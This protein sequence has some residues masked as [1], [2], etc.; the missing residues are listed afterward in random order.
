MLRYSWYF[1]GNSFIHRANPAVKITALLATY[2]FIL[3]FQNP[4]LIGILLISTIMLL[5]LSKTPFYLIREMVLPV[6]PVVVMF[7]V[8]WPIS[9]A[10][11]HV[12]ASYT[13]PGVGWVLN[14]TDLGMVWGLIVALRLFTTILATFLVMVTTSESDL[15]SGLLM[16]R[17]PYTLAFILILT[18]RFLSL[19]A[20][21][22]GTIHDA[23]RARALPDKQTMKESIKNMVTLVIPLLL[24]SVRRMQ[25]VTNAIEVRAFK[26]GQPRTN[27]HRLSFRCNDY[28]LM[29]FFVASALCASVLRLH[30]GA[31]AIIPGRP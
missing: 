9:F 1:S 10:E 23:R 12:L 20:G 15:V 27:Y 11:G 24:V 7:T 14:I 4:V 25:Y 29:V 8:F 13:I 26:P 16:L 17:V 2:V 3:A 21:D 5:L 18:F 6:T 31:F 28:A 30:Y 19:V 22:V